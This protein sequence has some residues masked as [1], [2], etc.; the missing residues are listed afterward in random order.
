K[1]IL[2]V[3]VMNRSVGDRRFSEFII[4]GKIFKNK[5]ILSYLNIVGK[6]VPCAKIINQDTGLGKMNGA[7]DHRFPDLPTHMQIGRELSPQVPDYVA[8]IL[9]KGIQV[10]ALHGDIEVQII[11]LLSRI[12]LPYYNQGNRISPLNGGV[13]RKLLIDVVE[14]RTNDSSSE[15]VTV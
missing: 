1:K 4:E 15:R 7:I 12:V 13:D 8:H 6:T 2:K 10:D 9:R 5:L 14:R 11:F 3:I